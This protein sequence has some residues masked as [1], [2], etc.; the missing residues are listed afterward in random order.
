MKEVYGINESPETEIPEDGYAKSRQFLDKTRMG[1]EEDWGKFRSKKNETK[2]FMEAK[3]GNGA[4]NAGREG[5]IKYGNITLKF[6]CAWDDTSHLYGDVNEYSL[7][8]YL[9]DNTVE[10]ISI[11][12]PNNPNRSRLLKR[13]K[14]P[15]DFHDTTG[16]G[17]RPPTESFFHY[18]DFYIGME[19]DVYGRTLRIVDADNLTREFFADQNMPLSESIVPP[20]PE[21]VVH[22]REVPPP[23]GFGS[24]EDSLR[25]VAGSLMPGPPPVKKMGENK[26]LSF[27]CSLLSG[28]VDDV[29]R[30]FVLT[31]YVQDN[32]LKV[33]EPPVRNSGFVGGTFLS[34]RAVKRTSAVP[35]SNASTA[36]TSG[37]IDYI[38]DKDLY[39]GC[40]LRILM[41][42][43][44]LLDTSDS[45]LR[46]MEDKG[47]PRSNVF[48]VLD[49][50]RPFL[51]SDARN[52]SLLN[53]F[54]FYERQMD[55]SDP[56]A[57]HG[58]G[59]VTR[60]ELREVLK[61]YGLVNPM[62]SNSVSEH[63]LITIQR[64]QGNKL[65][66]FEYEKFAQQII[67]PTADYK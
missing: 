8:Y 49:K 9:A 17:A 15:K 62:D 48:A 7:S 10:I 13:S 66:T 4:N 29:D 28:G 11:P 18:V 56:Q 52:G 47:L 24:E 61:E 30:R 55:K 43:F 34:R 1:G 46:W 60:N 21:I 57:G 45:T 36:S 37:A 25:S 54:E 65:P 41:H 19:L 5:F 27:L 53:K 51:I 44:L 3:L 40:R 23:T 50:V 67:Q 32:T 63:E 39:V 64:A 35:S 20:P 12:T 42:E 31:Y 14:L 22:E 38:T 6:R 2:I 58:P 16:L 33:V 59:R 26:Q